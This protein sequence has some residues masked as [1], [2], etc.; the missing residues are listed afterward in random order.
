[1]TFCVNGTLF[2][3]HRVVFNVDTTLFPSGTH[4]LQLVIVDNSGDPEHSGDGEVTTTTSP[5]QVHF[6]N[7]IYAV[8]WTGLVERRLV[9]QVAT[10]VQE[11]TVHLRVTDN[12]DR[13]WFDETGDV[14]DF[15]QADGTILIEDPTEGYY[16]GVSSFK[17]QV[18]ITP[19][20]GFAPS[21]PSSEDF[22]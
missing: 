9:M 11:G 19:A 20:P 14:N 2:T 10:A 15:R 7:V 6:D 18:T 12:L 17:L 1:M 21:N 4:Q 5:V 3:S 16:S 13:E 22:S 8:E